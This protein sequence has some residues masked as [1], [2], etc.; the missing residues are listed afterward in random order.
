MVSGRGQLL[1]I[2]YSSS[3]KA[4]LA[5]IPSPP[6][7]SMRSSMALG[8]EP[9]WRT[10]RVMNCGTRASRAFEKRA[11]PWRRSRPRPG[12][13]RSRQRASTFTWPTAGWPR[14]TARRWTS[15]TA[16]TPRRASLAGQYIAGADTDGARKCRR[17]VTEAFFAHFGD[18]DRG[19]TM[20]AMDRLSAALPVRGFAAWAAVSTGVAV[21]AEYVVAAHSKWGLFL[22]EKDPAAAA[23]F[24]T[25]AASLGFDSLEVAKMWSKLSQISV[26]A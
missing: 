13:G 19:V 17:L 6:V 2:K 15:S 23:A 7:D 14:S 1:R 10:R 16:C 3:S 21:D 11:W 4:H 12:T 5:V 26:I 20:P 22:A 8:A 18:F 25:E 9:A 24:R